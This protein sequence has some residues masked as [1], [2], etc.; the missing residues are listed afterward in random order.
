MAKRHLA[1]LMYTLL[2]LPL[3]GLAQEPPPAQVQDQD[4]RSDQVIEPALN[5]RDIKIPRI[6]AKDL[7]FGV[8]YGVYS[9]EDFGSAQLSGVRLAY[10]VSEDI[11]FEG[12]YGSSTVT[13]RLFR[14]LLPSGI[15]ENEEEKLTYYSASVGYNFFPGEIFLTKQRAMTSAVY[16]IGGIGNTKFANENRATVNFG[17]GIRMLPADWFAVRIDMRDNIF[18]SDIVGTTK[19]TNNFEMH[20]GIAVYF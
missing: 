16:V 1:M 13:D 6:K 4:V 8:Y 15:F 2:A 18:E 19:T 9:A 5:R 12:A 11:F 10:H 20:A 7:E 17:I 14:S 3:A